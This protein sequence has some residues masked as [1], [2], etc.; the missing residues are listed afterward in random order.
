MLNLLLILHAFASVSSAHPFAVDPKSPIAS[1]VVSI[2]RSAGAGRTW[3]NLPLQWATVC[4][5]FYKGRGL[6][7]TAAHCMFQSAGAG[8]S[9]IPL[10]EMRVVFGI[11][12]HGNDPQ[13]VRSIEHAFV[14]RQFRLS[15]GSCVHGKDA[16]AAD[17]C[18]GKGPPKD[19]ALLEISLERPAPPEP[20][21]TIQSLDSDELVG[22]PDLIAAGFG[23]YGPEPG[24]FGVLGVLDL[25]VRVDH[26]LARNRASRSLE[27]QTLNMLPVGPGDIGGPLFARRDGRLFAVG[28][29]TSV[30]KDGHWGRSSYVDLSYFEEWIFL[31][32]RSRS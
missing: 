18:S 11:Y 29:L 3:P 19:L 22:T 12:A 17:R 9:R 2:Q 20:R 26:F 24:D 15:S 8:M 25:S 27:L 5:G 1:Q 7:L 32:T 31:L 23:F 13:L 28:I 6:V 21:I 10:D 14:P 16:L 30:T 4:S